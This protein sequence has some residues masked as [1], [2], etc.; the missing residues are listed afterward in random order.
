MLFVQHFGKY[1]FYYQVVLK[2]FSKQVV[3]VCGFLLHS[4]LNK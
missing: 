1:M 3:S 2:D 4:I